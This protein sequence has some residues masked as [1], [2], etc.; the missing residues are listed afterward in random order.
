MS[1]RKALYVLLLNFFYHPV[2]NLGDGPVVP[3]QKYISGW[4]VEGVA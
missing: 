4:V 2:S 3:R 1:G